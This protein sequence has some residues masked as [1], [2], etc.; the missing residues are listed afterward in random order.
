M[1]ILDDFV[2]KDM[3]E[4]ITLLD[5]I[6]ENRQIDA[7]DGLL[8]LCANPLGDQAVDEMIY[9]CLFDLLAGQDEA[10]VAGLNH[11]SPA[12]QLICVR[13]AVDGGSTEL[14][15][16]LLSLLETSSDGEIIGEVVRALVGFK[17]PELVDILLPFLSYE[18]CGVVAWTMQGLTQMQLPKVRDALM[19]LVRQSAAVTDIEAL[20]CELPTA[21]AVENLACFHDA[22][23][24]DF[25]V[26]YIHQSNPSFRRV[27]ISALSGAGEDVLPA[28]DRCLS[29]GDKDER[30]MAANIMGMSRQKK[31]A[32]LLVSQL[33]SADDINLRFAIYEALGRIPS[34]RSVVCL[35]DGLAEED[36]L[37][38]M[39]VIIALE[40]QCNPGVVKKINEI[41]AANNEQSKRLLAALIAAHAKGLFLALYKSGEQTEMIIS[42]IIGSGDGEAM[43]LFKQAMESLGDEQALADAKKMEV[44]EV[45]GK[46][47]RLLAADDSKAMLFFYK[48]VAADLDFDLVTVED[49]QQAWEFLQFDTDFDLLITDMNMPN[50]DGIELSKAVRQN[51]D[52]EA[53]PILMATTESEG[54]QSEIARQAGVTNFITKPFS[55]DEFKAKILDLL[56]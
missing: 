11:E 22:E 42:A 1:N 53:M 41:L 35:V 39:S 47:K 21:M 46:E 14:K 55:K 43:A 32:D 44:G 7:L 29:E 54:S 9:H 56:S 52:T 16:A 30:I 18:D 20:G 4:Q 17:D 19:E 15:T 2:N 27:V 23:T 24:I 34:M 33:S 26:G 31:A 49:G 6:K 25:L 13:R 12:V 10:L 28:L 40:Q 51:K 36:E 38:L 3:I 5:E 50:M 45:Q 8:E 48:A 37:V